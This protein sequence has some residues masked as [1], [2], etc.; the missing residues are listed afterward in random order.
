MS[1]EVESGVPQSW[2][3][4]PKKRTAPLVVLF[5]IAAFF[6]GL[7][8]GR[9]QGGQGPSTSQANNQQDDDAGGAH[10]EN[11]ATAIW[12]CSMHPQVRSGEPG[13]CP[14]CGMDLIPVEDGAAGGSNDDAPN[15][16]T[17]TGRAKALSRITTTVVKRAAADA[18]ELRLLGRLDYDERRVRTVTSWTEGRIDRLHVAVTGQRVGRGQVIATLYSPEI[19]SAQQDMIQASRQVKRLSKGTQTARLAADA[20]LESTRERLRLLGVPEGELTKMESAERPFRH[21]SIRANAGGTVIERLVDEGAYVNPGS[22]IYRVA[23]LSK[24]WVQLDAYERDL[25]FISRGQKVG[26]SISAFPEEAFEGTVAFID[27]V[28]NSR[29]RT[30]RLRVEVNNRDGR[31]QPGMFAEATVQ[32]GNG[33]QALRQLVIPESAPLFT[34]R[35][36]VVYVEVPDSEQPTYE[37]R[38]VR[39]GHKTGDVYPV[40]AGIGEGERVV[41]QG[42]FTLDADLQIRGGQSMMAQPDDRSPGLH[43]QIVRADPRFMSSLLPVLGSYLSAQ[44]RL[45]ED[46]HQAAKVA[47]QALEREVGR[48][49]RPR[50][51][52][53]REAWTTIADGLR[54]HAAHGAGTADIEAARAAFEHLSL[55]M[56]T[57]LERFGNPL[58]TPL[59][60]AFCPMAF[61][62]RGAEWIQRGE[63]IDNSYFGAVMRRCG[64]IRATVGPGEHLASNDE[65]QTARTPSAGG[66]DH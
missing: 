32:G 16:V 14:L 42:A 43:D 49:Q 34:G 62:N 45:G 25:A 39:L 17:L 52:E 23:D 29:T 40:I 10:G 7:M 22:G 15:R 35:R 8:L 36:S 59:R 19:Y 6:L 53:A 46:D 30:T 50:S 41:V 55:Q 28:L 24:L 38:Q 27:P 61:D 54:Q 5:V 51:A 64:S 20:A 4:G 65:S 18:V 21:I 37:A 56:R 26:L 31:L 44:E 63:E 60:L 47:M 1:D 57:L 48:V 33:E 3:F 11:S 66:H 12:T 2:R 58:S 13:Q 9:G